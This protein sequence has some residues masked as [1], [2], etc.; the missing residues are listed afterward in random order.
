MRVL[1]GIIIVFT[2]YS[3]SESIAKIKNEKEGELNA[4]I[5]LVEVGSKSFSLDSDTAPQPQ[6]IQIVKDS[7]GTREITFLN[8]YNN[9]IYYYNYDSS[10]FTNKITFDKNG[11]DAI[12]NP[13][14]YYIKNKDSIY[15]YDMGTADVKI[16]NMEGRVS[17]SI[18]LR[19]VE[20]S[21]TWFSQYPQYIPRTVIPLMATNDELML[22]GQ[23]MRTV[24][25][26]MVDIFRFTSHVNFKTNKVHFTHHYPRELYGNNYN[27]EGE[28]FTD[29]YPLLDVANKRFIYSFPISHR[30]YISGINSSD[31]TKVYAGSNEVGTIESIDKEPENVNRTE[32]LSHI[33]KTDEYTAILYD[34]YREVYYRFLLK[35]IPNAKK[36][37]Q[38]KEKELAVIVM[39]KEFNYLG[40]TIIGEWKEWNWYNSFVT[41]E[42]LNIE[43]LE[44]SDIE[45]LYLNLKIFIPEKL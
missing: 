36:S 26:D 18:S 8:N 17:N 5:K 38:F 39:D 6:Y 34:K 28:I 21:K 10:Q 7:T 15:I 44:K 29:V 11:P 37:T 27:W 12:K 3:C 24:P 32:L 42:G 20:D 33:I 45:E 25:E 19:G 1:L 9:S 31:Y 43:F 40:E 35:S 4:S 30:L 13:M 2:F 16:S 41:E 22:T 14:G 23:I